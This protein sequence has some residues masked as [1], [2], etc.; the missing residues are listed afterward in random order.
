VDPH[1]TSLARKHATLVAAL[2]SASEQV[3]NL[4]GYK[5]PDQQDKSKE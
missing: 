5:Q 2:R 1:F 3:Q 4:A